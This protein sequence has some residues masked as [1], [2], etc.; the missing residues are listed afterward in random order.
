MGW[1]VVA[2]DLPTD[3]RDIGSLPEE[4]SPQPLGNRSDL[5]RKIKEVYPNANFDRPAYG[6]ILTPEFVIEVCILQED[7]VMTIGFHVHGD[8]S[9]AVTVIGDILVHLDLRAVDLSSGDVFTRE[10]ALESFEAWRDW[11]NRVLSD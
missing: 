10:N 6:E 3:C 4:F 1:D 11:K 5:I 7:D 9:M 2:M 8:D